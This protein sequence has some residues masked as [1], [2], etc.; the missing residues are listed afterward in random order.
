[1]TLETMTEVDVDGYVD[2]RHGIQYLSK[3]T[4]QPNGTW[5]RLANVDGR[6][7]VVEVEITELVSHDG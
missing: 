5:R 3:A 1:M 6:L 7:C 2:E 4:K